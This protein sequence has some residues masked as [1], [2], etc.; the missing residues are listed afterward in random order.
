MNLMQSS[1]NRNE[2]PQGQRHLTMNDAEALR[3]ELSK[4]EHEVRRLSDRKWYVKKTLR[5]FDINRGR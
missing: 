1:I 3:I 2:R 5:A 4:L